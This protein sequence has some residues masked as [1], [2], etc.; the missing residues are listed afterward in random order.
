MRFSDDLL[1]RTQATFL[2]DYGV[3]LTLDET[4]EAL[5]NLTKYIKTLMEIDRKQKSKH[6]RNDQVPED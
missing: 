3:E 1:K 2:K 6:E 4:N 5:K